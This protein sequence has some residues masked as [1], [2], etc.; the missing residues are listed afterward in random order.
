LEV[1]WQCTGNGFVFNSQ[2]ESW[3]NMA[4]LLAGKE[5]Q[6][7]CAFAY[8]GLGYMLGGINCSNTCLNDFWQYNPVNNSWSALPDFP[9]TARQGMSY[10]ILNGK[11]FITGGKFTDGTITAEVWEYNFSNGNWTQKNNLPFNGMWRGSAFEIFGT[12]YV[13]FGKTN[14]GNYNRK[15]YRYHATNDTWQEY[16][17][18]HL[19]ALNYIGTGVGSGKALLYGGQDSLGAITNSLYVFNPAD[20]SLN[21][22][23]GIPTLGRKGGMAFSIGQVLYISTGLDASPAR[24]RET[25]K[26]DYFVGFREQPLTENSVKMYPNPCRSTLLIELENETINLIQI[27]DLSGKI[28]L[29]KSFISFETKIS[30]NVS[31]IPRGCYLVKMNVKNKLF[32]KK[33][34]LIN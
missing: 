22:F 34:M 21:T 30:M 2:T 17:N 12:A 7:A 18:I 23:A 31:E 16:T 32:V 15:I 24:T 14:S 9:G 28:V 4:S 33:L 19:P 6:Y 1:G 29:E 13:C 11:A 25:W 10:F 27:C 5:R 8:N 3:E 20:S 26:N